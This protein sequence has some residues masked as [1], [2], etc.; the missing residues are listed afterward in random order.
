MGRSEREGG[1]GGK[2]GEREGMNERVGKNEEG[3]K[4][5][6]RERDGVRRKG[7]GM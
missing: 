5:R 2:E 3:W 4:C 6:V 1:E 7:E